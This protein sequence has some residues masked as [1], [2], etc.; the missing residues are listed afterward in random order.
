MWDESFEPSY[1]VIGQYLSNKNEM[2]QYQKQKILRSKQ[3]LR[4]TGLIRS[5][6]DRLEADADLSSGP[7]WFL[8][9]RD[10]LKTDPETKCSSAQILKQIL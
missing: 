3:G 4:L 5:P 7:S 1:S 8:N 10:K 2:L 9:P 6:T